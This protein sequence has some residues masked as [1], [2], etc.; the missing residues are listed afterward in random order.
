[1]GFLI[2]IIMGLTVLSGQQYE[3]KK[4][5]KKCIEVLRGV[6]SDKTEREFS[7]IVAQYKTCLIK[8]K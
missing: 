6:Y 7:R 5:D 3:E 2:A 8:N 4:N 1:M